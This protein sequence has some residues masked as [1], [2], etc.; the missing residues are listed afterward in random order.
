MR[1]VEQVASDLRKAREEEKASASKREK[2]ENELREIH[3]AA[4]RELDN[5][6][7]VS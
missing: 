6:G 7:S 5:I 1:T 2:F 3:A 4:S